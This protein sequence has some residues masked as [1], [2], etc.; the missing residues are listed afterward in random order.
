MSLGQNRF[1]EAGRVGK[2]SEG[3]FPD[4]C[5]KLLTNSIMF[6]TAKC[7][8]NMEFNILPLSGLLRW[9]LCRRE[10]VEDGKRE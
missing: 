2:L 6:T 3:H 4:V 1:N 5:S 7:T 10:V 9:G 8:G